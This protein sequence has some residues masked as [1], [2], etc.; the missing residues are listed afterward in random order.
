MAGLVARAQPITS[1]PGPVRAWLSRWW[2]D[3]PEIDKA[4]V[5]GVAV[6]GI[7]FVAAIGWLFIGMV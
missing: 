6:L 3:L 1:R 2:S 5:T 4:I 7:P